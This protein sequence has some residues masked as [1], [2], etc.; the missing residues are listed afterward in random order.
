MWR[1]V[2]GASSGIGRFFNQEDTK[3]QCHGPQCSGGGTG[4]TPALTTIPS[5]FGKGDLLISESG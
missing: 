1:R 2:S 3:A 4:P 5:K